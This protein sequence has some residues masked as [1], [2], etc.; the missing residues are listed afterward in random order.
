MRTLSTATI[1][2]LGTAAIA[3]SAPSV[4]DLQRS[5]HV[6]V[7][8]AT[9]AAPGG[10]VALLAQFGSLDLHL[11]GAI[12]GAFDTWEVTPS[13]T[14]FTPNDPFAG[15]Y[16]VR[17][18]GQAVFDLDPANPGTKLIDLWIAPDGSLLHT[19]RADADPEAL[20]VLAVAKSS[21]KSVASLNG[22]FAYAGQH[23]H[24]V[25]AALETTAMWGVITFDGVGGFTAA[26]MEMVATAAGSTTTPHTDVGNY[27][28]APDGAVTIDS[29]RGGMSDDGQMLFAGYAGTTGSEVGLAIAVRIG[30]SYDFHDLAG[31]YGLHAAGYTLGAGPALPRSTTQL[32]ELTFAATSSSAGTWNG[33]G[34]LAEANPLGQTLN[35]WTPGGTATLGSSGALQLTS[36]A[37]TL[38]LDVSAN[39]RYLI[40]RALGNATNLL[41]AMRQCAVAAAYGTGTAG[42]GGRVPVLGM[43]TFPV[44]GNGNWALVLGNGLG[45]GIG[46]IPIALAPLPGVP[47]LGGLLWVD[48]ATIGIIPLVL[49]G[50]A[51]GVPGAGQGQ[52]PLALPSTPSLA[53]I[54]LF[55]QGLILDTAA[56]GGFAMSNGFRAELSR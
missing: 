33:N 56:P 12:S 1:L 6:G 43:Q 32:A 21:G 38:A 29:D 18:D 26:G 51:V 16:F 41:F 7:Y 39:G 15:T 49:L 19:A 10:A 2:V 36:G 52:T 37:S 54:P 13:G 48:P 46:L 22:S 28:V 53:G 42:A 40:G 31:R 47:V 34:V 8:S 45:G 20:A 25:G 50:G 44:L 24:L 27:T 14:V 55:A 3:Q 4:L 23:L 35:P 11:G 17:P 9:I 30:P 5:Y